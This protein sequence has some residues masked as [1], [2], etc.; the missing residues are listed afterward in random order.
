MTK[1]TIKHSLEKL[2]GHKE[3]FITLFQHG[4]LEVEIYKPEKADL[5]KPHSRDEVYVIAT[6]TG[7]FQCAREKQPV[8]KGDVLFVPAGIEHRFLNF[9]DD[10]STWVFF[11]GPEGG[12][13]T[14]QP[15]P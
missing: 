1:L 10:F 12:E 5:Q 14:Q 15:R 2:S 6:G 8:E 9:S 3:K 7:E 4:S 13:T 11:Y